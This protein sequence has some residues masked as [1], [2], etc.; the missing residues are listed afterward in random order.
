MLTCTSDQSR[1]YTFGIALGRG[2]SPVAVLDVR[3]AVTEGVTSAPAI[4]TLAATLGVEMPIAGAVH[5]VLHRGASV[6]DAIGGLLARPFKPEAGAG[7][8]ARP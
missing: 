4:M 5:A 2:E 6:D 8:S 1:N 7:R 3:E